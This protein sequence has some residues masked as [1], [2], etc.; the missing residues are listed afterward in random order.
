MDY[1]RLLLTPEIGYAIVLATLLRV[2]RPAYL[3]FRK[4]RSAYG[5]VFNSV[6]EIP[7][8][9]ASVSLHDL[10]GR[11]VRTTVTDKHGRYRLLAPKGDFTIDVRKADFTY[12]S[13]YLGDPH[14]TFV[15][16]NI[17]STGRIIINDYGMITKNIPIDPA[18]GKRRASLIPHFTLGK[19]TQYA[20]AGLGPIVALAFAMWR[21]SIWT[22]IIF[23]LFMVVLFKRLFSFKPADPPFGTI[24]DAETKKPVANAIV[25]VFDAK[26]NKVLETQI[27]SPKGRYAF[28]VRTGAYY[29]LV[30]HEGYKTVRLNFPHIKKDGFLLVKDVHLKKQTGPEV[31]Y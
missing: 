18:S 4:R 30:K 26:S 2:T 24:F 12:P 8:A 20:L 7:E 25:R 14:H 13:K 3:A 31:D 19:R 1:L 28:I 17:L 10:S 16:D 29:V 27:T 9:L 22:W 6:T 11:V 23:A 15:Y 21:M 5:T